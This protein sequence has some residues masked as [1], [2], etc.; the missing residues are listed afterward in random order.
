MARW[1]TRGRR[2]GRRRVYP[3]SCNPGPRRQP[4]L[5]AASRAT[6]TVTV[7]EAQTRQV[8]VRGSRRGRRGRLSDVTIMPVGSRSPSLSLSPSLSPSL[9]LRAR[10]R[11]LSL[12]TVTIKSLS[13]RS[14]QIKKE[15]YC[16]QGYSN[17]KPIDCKVSLGFCR[18]YLIILLGFYRFPLRE[19]GSGPA[20]R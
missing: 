12:V 20:V 2:P 5:P 3:K 8:R 18:F 11:T 9:R 14:R 1:V 7:K 17:S 16:S 19:T 15:I 13:R 4:P 6:V 10:T